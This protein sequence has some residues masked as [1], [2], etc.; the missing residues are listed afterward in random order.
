MRNRIK[1]LRAEARAH[2]HAALAKV[3]QILAELGDIDSGEVTHWQ[4]CECELLDAAGYLD[5]DDEERPKLKV[6]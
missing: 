2:V 3:R 5:E 1:S 6:V 4:Y